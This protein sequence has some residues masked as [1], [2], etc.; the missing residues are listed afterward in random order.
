MASTTETI[1]PDSLLAA[2][3]G[4][5]TANITQI[6]EAENNDWLTNDG[7][8]DPQI[9]HVSFPSPSGNLEEGAGLQTFRIYARRNQTN[10]VPTMDVYVYESGSLLLTLATAVNIDTT[11]S[12]YTYTWDATNLT[13]ISGADVEAYF[14][15][16][17]SG[18]GPNETWVDVDSVSWTAAV[19]L[20]RYF[21]FS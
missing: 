3:T 13:T 8:T 4:W 7:A 5:T 10:A 14:Q 2:T 11:G 21:F 1:Y 15:F 18:G 17:T 9:L 6:D 20:K 19:N 12:A 16:T